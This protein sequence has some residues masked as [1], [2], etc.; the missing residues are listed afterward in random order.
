[1]RDA[2]GK[3]IVTSDVRDVSFETLDGEQLLDCDRAFF[4]DSDKV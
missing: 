2:Q 1:L 3:E 4:S